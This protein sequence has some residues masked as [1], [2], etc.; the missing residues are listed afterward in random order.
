MA[1]NE[2]LENVRANLE[3]K[4]EATFNAVENFSDFY[5]RF[6]NGLK[7]IEKDNPDS[8][9]A[10]N[11]K[12]AIMS[13]YIPSEMRV[14]ADEHTMLPSSMQF[15]GDE[16]QNEA[17]MLRTVTRGS[18]AMGMGR[19]FGRFLGIDTTIK[20]KDYLTTGGEKVD[21]KGSLAD[22]IADMSSI[23][24]ITGTWNDRGGIFEKMNIPGEP[25]SK[26]LDQGA[27]TRKFTDLGI[28]TFRIEY[29]NGSV[30]EQ[31]FLANEAG[32][33]YKEI[34]RANINGAIQNLTNE[35]VKGA[36]R[37]FVS[38]DTRREAV[39]K[40]IN[41]HIATL[42]E[43]VYAREE[44]KI[45][46]Y[47]EVRTEAVERTKDRMDGLKGTL[48]SVFAEYSTISEKLGELKGNV[49]SAAKDYAKA[50]E[51][52]DSV[53]ISEKKSEFESAYKEYVSARND[54]K[55]TAETVD[56]VLGAKETEEAKFYDLSSLNDFTYSDHATE[57]KLD[58][59]MQ[60]ND[61]KSMFYFTDSAGDV[62]KLAPSKEGFDVLESRVD[63]YNKNH[64]D[65][66]ISVDYDGIVHDKD[67]NEVD[68]SDKFGENNLGL[69]K[70]GDRENFEIDSPKVLIE[71]NLED[72]DVEV[73]APDIEEPEKKIEA[74][75]EREEK[76]LE[77]EKEETPVEIEG[78]TDEDDTTKKGADAKVLDK[79]VAGKVANV[80]RAINMDG[81]V[82]L[83]DKATKDIKQS[84]LKSMGIDTNAYNSRL[85]AV[86]EKITLSESEKDQIKSDVL[87][88][89]KGNF[90][91]Y[92]KEVGR[93]T[94]VAKDAK[95]RDELYSKLGT[96]VERVN[97]IRDKKMDSITLSDK[98]MERIDQTAKSRGGNDADKVAAVKAELVAENK[99]RIAE[100]E[101]RKELGIDEKAYQE[102]RAQMRENTSLTS[103]EKA[104]IEVSARET[105]GYDEKVFQERY[106]EKESA[107]REEKAEQVVNNEFKVDRNT[108]ESKVDQIKTQ[109]LTELEKI[110]NKIISTKMSADSLEWMGSRLARRNTTYTYDIYKIGKLTS[111]YAK[112][113][114]QVGGDQFVKREFTTGEKIDNFFSFFNS[115][116][117][118]TG[119]MN[120]ITLFRKDETKVDHGVEKTAPKAEGRVTSDRNIASEASVIRNETRTAPNVEVRPSSA[121]ETG[122]VDNSRSDNTENK[123]SRVDASNEPKEK[124]NVEATKGEGS[125]E[126]QKK[127]AE[128]Q[129]NAIT[130]EENAKSQ[131]AVETSKDASEP[132]SVEAEESYSDENGAVS[133][134]ESG[135]V[136]S[137]VA[138]ETEDKLEVPVETENEDVTK[139]NAEA[140]ENDDVEAEQNNIEAEQAEQ[141]DVIIAEED[142]EDSEE[143]R[144]ESAE[145]D[146]E[147]ASEED[148]ESQT[149]EDMEAEDEK[150]SATSEEETEEPGNVTAEEGEEEPDEVTAEETADD[151]TVEDIGE[152]FVRAENTEEQAENDIINEVQNSDAAVAE[153][154]E[155]E[156]PARIETESEEA[157]NDQITDENNETDIS[158]VES[159]EKRDDALVVDDADE[160]T[161]TGGGSGDVVQKEGE[162]PVVQED[163]GDKTVD[164]EGTPKPDET[165]MRDMFTDAL[166]G[167]NEN[168]YNDV[169]QHELGSDL[170]THESVN[171]IVDAFKDAV[172]DTFVNEM[173]QD[174]KER[175][176]D[177]VNTIIDA[178]SS[179]SNIAA[180]EF[181][182]GLEDAVIDVFGTDNGN[183][184]VELMD[185]RNEMPEI[186]AGDGYET[187]SY[188]EDPSIAPEY[189]SD[190][191]MQDFTEDVPRS[192]IS[193]PME[194]TALRDQLADDIEI[195]SNGTLIPIDATVIADHL[196]DNGVNPE[197]ITTDQL[198]NEVDAYLNDPAT[199]LSTDNNTDDVTNG[200]VIDDGMNNDFGN[201]PNSDLESAAADVESAPTEVDSGSAPAEETDLID[202]EEPKQAENEGNVDMP[203]DYEPVS[204]DSGVDASGF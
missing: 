128:E 204:F 55:V 69:F 127:P 162:Q 124:I 109:K 140:Q 197:N 134:D 25:G 186:E 45:E 61:S 175:A 39:D 37:F 131:D 46:Q 102:E 34:P 202:V 119:I 72:K 73:E 56:T 13:G 22:H 18:E 76:G 68:L 92:N 130:T 14:G 40:M 189:V 38:G 110:K 3:V 28:L 50:L 16:K 172:K 19:E 97:E 141:D 184:I 178:A 57:S 64:P 58:A 139:E 104:K 51:S 82:E 84:V 195:I 117:V 171:E 11:V 21:F 71:K 122:N 157:G 105:A 138:A 196:I 86:K 121:V 47:K 185:T 32:H 63:E 83:S 153:A 191:A 74:D 62:T 151:E 168:L 148:V 65:E 190:T 42:P 167:D 192:E 4:D 75:V 158:S 77:T 137:N 146:V 112:A 30:G 135:D 193:E 94:N 183:D 144:M 136:E 103:D 1:V 160:I 116:I 7:E 52:K 203:E 87:K 15:K 181:R 31:A 26:R 44:A 17:G 180:E 20:G 129:S 194:Q 24:K 89:M 78:R 170:D 115:N 113:G 198:Q 54:V 179:A 114:G 176:A 152:D 173:T 5:E 88:G 118:E 199:Y 90:S 182:T 188:E 147:E 159:E 101:A 161:A 23:N 145:E 200:G 174:D 155:S 53:Q 12:E 166:K 81:K 33:V 36:N 80:D 95:C 59:A 169:L 66:Q 85:E 126:S 48:N 35:K 49:E 133:S 125:V 8:M 164:V 111:A 99:S 143:D 79:L 10:A 106:T 43:K 154:E 177:T 2:F 156:E 201:N 187:V 9:M 100:F 29:K 41:E 27:E 163:A 91:T 165:S 107:V 96:S 93:L 6:D 67:G 120:I 142:A 149:E 108:Y 98:Q 70:E 60:M 123:G 150:D 132:D